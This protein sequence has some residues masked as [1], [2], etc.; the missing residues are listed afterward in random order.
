MFIKTTQLKH[1]KICRSLFIGL[2]TSLM[3][4]SAVLVNAQST[5]AGKNTTA[6]SGSAEEKTYDG[7]TIA[8]SAE[9]GWRWRS[10]DG[11]ENKY[12]SDLNYKPGFRTFDSNLFIHSDSGKGKYFD[13][14]LI[15]NSGWGSDPNGYFRVNMEKIGVYKYN[16]T[17]RRISYF[18]NLSNYVAVPDPNQHTQN[19]DNTMGDVDITF[20]PQNKLI[21]FNLGAS[22]GNYKGPGTTTM[23][24]NGDEFKI[25]SRTS[26]KTADFRFGVDGSLAGFD[27]GLTES[28]RK[29]RDRSSFAINS[30]NQGN[31]TPT[32]TTPPNTTAVSN[33]SRLFPTDGQAYFSQFNLHRTIADKLD[34]TGRV[35]YSTTDTVM[36]LTEIVLGRDASN[37]FIDS[38]TY[39]ANAGSKRPQTRTDLGATYNVTNDFRISNTFTFDQFAVNGG[40]NFSQ[41][42]IRRNSSGSGTNRPSRSKTANIRCKS[43]RNFARHFI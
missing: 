43:P 22:L 39:T 35:I 38:D 17:L 36:N 37:N 29:Y 11:N 19:T 7:Y 27:W 3:L 13:S 10:I 30:L 5:A 4:V 26:N 33:F 2:L 34:F 9:I 21:R 42:A 18:N 6:P 41:L 14:L 1:R 12:R 24:W 15:S 20:L 8:A 40:E 23:R 31:N 32:N 16:S 25:D 28:I